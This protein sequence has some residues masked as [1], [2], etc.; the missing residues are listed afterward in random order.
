[1]PR[2]KTELTAY[3]NMLIFIYMDVHV[4]EKFP[5]QIS[6]HGGDM[7]FARK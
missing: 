5:A 1:M 7:L 2:V 3:H 6:Y 4:A